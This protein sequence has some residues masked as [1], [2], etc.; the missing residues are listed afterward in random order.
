MRKLGL[1]VLVSAFTLSGVALLLLSRP[2]SL[3]DLE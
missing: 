2:P 3:K 1:L